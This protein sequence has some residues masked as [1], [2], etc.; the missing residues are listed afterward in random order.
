MKNLF[1]SLNKSNADDGLRRTGTD[2]V[3]RLTERN[4]KFEAFLLEKLADLE[5]KII[6]VE[7]TAPAFEE[8]VP[9]P[10]TTPVP[11]SPVDPVATDESFLSDKLLGGTA[12]PPAFTAPPNTAADE[13]WM[14]GFDE[15]N[16]PA[17]GAPDT[18]DDTDLPPDVDEVL[19]DND[20]Q[21][22]DWN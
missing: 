13:N 7:P 11:D 2:V 1:A 21:K 10:S 6:P 12:A 3:A 17:A 15:D 22:G 20:G 9:P 4:R 5:S 18:E 8:D 14:A 16:P 19:P